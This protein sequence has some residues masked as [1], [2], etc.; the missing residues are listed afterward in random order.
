MLIATDNR[1][2]QLLITQRLKVSMPQTKTVCV[3]TA[4]ETLSYLRTAFVEFYN[5][6]R[7]LLLDVSLSAARGWQLLQEIRNTYPL[8]SVVLISTDEAPELVLQAYELGAHAF[9]SRS[10]DAKEW[11]DKLDTLAHYWLQIVTL[12]KQPIN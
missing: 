2:D 9:V 12:P 5:F 4:D 6:P 8:L 1:A 3:A 7:L 10:A 11:Q